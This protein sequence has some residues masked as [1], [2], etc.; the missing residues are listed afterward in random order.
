MNRATLL[1]RLG[2]DPETRQ[3]KAGDVVR[4][5][6]ATNDRR[7]DARTGDWVEATEWHTVTCFGKLAETVARFC[8]KGRSV[9]VEGKIRTSEYTNKQGEQRR[10]TE[11]VADRV[12]FVG[13]RDSAD[14][15]QARHDSRQPAQDARPMSDI[16]F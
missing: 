8:S 1:G 14:S 5:R 10:S 7:K 13:S 12:H 11:I 16:P 2:S 4:F 3:T 15:G 6:L 9:C